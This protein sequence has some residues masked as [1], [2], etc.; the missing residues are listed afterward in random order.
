MTWNAYHRRGEVLSTAIATADARRDGR[1]PTDVD[2]VRATFA[3]DL[4]LL[5]TL[6]L[7][8]HTRLSG[9][10]D[11]ALST[12]P[13]DLETAVADAWAAT[14]R[15]MPG[16]RAVLDGPAADEIG[17]H[18]VR[19][20]AGARAKERSMLAA[21]AGRASYDD[22]AAAVVGAAIEERARLRLDEVPDDAAA[23][24]CP[25]SGLLGR[26]RAALAA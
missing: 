8:W 7:R 10:I 23:T 26:L 25:A 5:G 12:Q 21:M 9:R 20:M 18:A 17:E 6:Q 24:A 2:G 4:D 13:L 3:D 14:A 19:V 16:V 1:L 11:A 22:A 15:D